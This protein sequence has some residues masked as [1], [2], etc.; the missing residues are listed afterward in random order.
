MLQLVG[1][2]YIQ[3]IARGAGMLLISATVPL[4]AQDPAAIGGEGKLPHALVSVS[5]ASHDASETILREIDD[6]STGARWLLVADPKHPGGPG[7][8]VLAGV[9]SRTAEDAGGVMAQALP[10][11]RPGDHL[12]IE[13]HTK[14]TD[15]CLEAIAMGTAQKGA[16][17]QARLKVTGTVVK[18]IA[19]APGRAEFA[20]EWR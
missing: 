5:T 16:P 1:S 19:L 9:E 4:A 8:M 14:V 12:L 6:P 15:A 3:R 17:L 20:P 13:E 11:I 7:R 2:R 10:V 18:A